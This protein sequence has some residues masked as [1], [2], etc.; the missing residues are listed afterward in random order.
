ME[1]LR[2]KQFILIQGTA[3]DNVH[4]QQTMYLSKALTNKG[5]LYKSQIY[6][7]EGHSLLNVRR[8]LWRTLSGFFDDCFR[9]TVSKSSLFII[10]Y[11]PESALICPDFNNVCTYKC[12]YLHL[13]DKKS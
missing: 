8:H 3:D 2:D 10:I 1:N 7:D 4:L 13:F 5:V 9:K 11:T 6:P 12:K